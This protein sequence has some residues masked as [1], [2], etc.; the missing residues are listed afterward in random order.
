MPAREHTTHLQ[1]AFM[2]LQSSEPGGLPICCHLE[3]G[4]CRLSA[5]LSSLQGLTWP[6]EALFANEDASGSSGKAPDVALLL[7][8]SSVSA[9]SGMDGSLQQCTSV[10]AGVTPWAC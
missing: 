4:I 3:S 2:P 10:R 8:A 9:S 7:G 1:V 6:K 5:A